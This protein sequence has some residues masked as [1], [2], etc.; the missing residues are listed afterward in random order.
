MIVGGKRGGKRGGRGRGRGKVRGG[1]DQGLDSKSPAAGGLGINSHIIIEEGGLKLKEGLGDADTYNDDSSIHD[2]DLDSPSEI[3]FLTKKKNILNQ[4]FIPQKPRKNT[5]EEYTQIDD[6]DSPYQGEDKNDLDID[7]KDTPVN[8]ASRIDIEVEVPRREHESSY[9]KK[10]K[11]FEILDPQFIFGNDSPS[12]EATKNS[13][14]EDFGSPEGESSERDISDRLVDIEFSSNKKNAIELL[15]SKEQVNKLDEKTSEMHIEIPKTIP[16]EESQKEIPNSDISSPKGDNFDISSP[17]EIS[18]QKDGKDDEDFSSP[19]EKILPE[20]E[21]TIEVNQAHVSPKENQEEHRDVGIIIEEDIK[22][23]PIITEKSPV[24]QK[25]IHFSPSHEQNISQPNFIENNSF[26]P[27]EHE[28]LGMISIEGQEQSHRHA[29]IAKS[30]KSSDKSPVFGEC[31]VDLMHE[32]SSSLHLSEEDDDEEEKEKEKEKEKET[33]SQ[34]K[35]IPES[36]EIQPNEMQ[37]N[38]MQPA[39]LD[40]NNFYYKIERVRLPEGKR[41]KGFKIVLRKIIRGSADDVPGKRYKKKPAPR[42][43]RPKVTGEGMDDI[44][45]PL[46]INEKYAP[47][48]YTDAPRR[49]LREKKDKPK[50]YDQEN[51]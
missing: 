41:K 27:K 36:K 1:I 5:N 51:R 48:F 44:N 3:T 20:L 8:P 12:R 4:I 30:N 43:V 32:G 38:E 47:T 18:F 33:G 46:Y 17:K 21:E 9:M 15:E 49:S 28:E 10:R 6:L 35:E 25:T 37:S 2:D 45:D 39:P 13:N 34:I 42:T 14:I 29:S 22:K 11:S 23:E 19:K 24:V 50:L 16:D 31:I 7:G 40:E 26:E